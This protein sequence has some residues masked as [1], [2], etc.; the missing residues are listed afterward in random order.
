VDES[1]RGER[2]AAARLTI[3]QRMV[4]TL[5][6]QFAD[7]ALHWR[8]RLIG[9]G[10]LLL[11]LRPGIAFPSQ[12]AEQLASGTVSELSPLRMISA[13]ALGVLMALAK[14]VRPRTIAPASPTRIAPSS[15]YAYACLNRDV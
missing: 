1:A 9:T 11:L 13:K 2:R 14:P 8:Y 7:P 5:T 6:T 15:M 3:A 12:L 4:T 10:A